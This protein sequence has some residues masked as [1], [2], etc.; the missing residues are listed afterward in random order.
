MHD[1][2]VRERIEFFATILLA[3]ATVL[4][5]WSAFQ[6][7]KWNG[8]EAVHFANAS[9]LR[10][11]S[12]KAD[13]TANAQQVVDVETFVSWASAVADE[14]R[15]D[16]SASTGPDGAYVPEPDALSGFLFERLRDEFQPAVE[17][18]LAEDPLQDPEAPPTPFD[19]PE[20]Q[21][22]EQERAEQLDVDAD[23]EAKVAR[24]DNQ[25]GDNYVLATVLFASVL[26]FAGLSG[27]LGSTRNRLITI[28][29]AVVLLGSG[30]ALLAVFP[31]KL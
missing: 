21:L 2:R 1:E 18:W 20:Y 30:L 27:K 11:E 22:A 28:T 16:P 17:A 5:A 29:F 12:A 24:R 10:T 26:F 31:T 6:S 3:F 9:A 23:E 19:M 8:S 25:R 4:T 14:R 7:T 15:T 13:D